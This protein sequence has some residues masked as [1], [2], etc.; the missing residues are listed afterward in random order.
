M[1]GEGPRTGK[2]KICDIV[3]SS[4][5]PVAL[6]AAV[7]EYMGMSIPTHVFAASK[8]GTGTYRFAR[9]G[10]NVEPNSFKLAKP[11]KQPIFRWEMALRRTRLKPII[12]DTSLFEVFAFIA[13]KYN[14][15]W[16]YQLKGKGYARKIMKTWYGK[17]LS[18][19]IK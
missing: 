10:D 8:R 6:D 5:D 16:Y 17:E 11:D 14:T 15:F 4:K 9:V 12:F 19:F 7:A 3:M 1:E 13:T 18:K 2:P